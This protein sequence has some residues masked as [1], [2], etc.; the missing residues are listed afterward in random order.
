MMRY[1]VLLIG[2]T[3]SLPAQMPMGGITSAVVTALDGQARHFSG[4]ASDT[5][6]NS[7]AY[8]SGGHTWTI[9]MWIKLD[10]TTQTN[11]Y[12]I[13]L[14]DSSQLSIVFGYTAG[15][16]TLYCNTCTGD[17]NTG[18]QIASGDINWHAIAYRSDGT[19]LDK[20]L[21]GTKTSYGTRS[22]TLSALPA[23]LTVGN[24]YSGSA[25]ILASIGRIL[26]TGSALTDEQISA[27]ATTCDVSSISA[28]LGY[29][30]LS[31]GMSPEP[32]APPSSNNHS[33]TV[34]GTT[35]V[36]GPTACGLFWTSLS[37]TQWT[38]LSN[39]QWTTMG[40]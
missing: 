20:F 26:I 32:E 21:D 34:S 1:L 16:F 29:W 7:T 37:N 14:G 9:M 11:K 35:V 17:V 28:P 18:S 27:F 38:K 36:S 39:S 24:A 3:L 40:N 22:I 30:P 15:N 6:T 8:L 10:N 5:L 23:H 25:P 2:C 4:V 12:A 13:V 31:S 33:L 19:T